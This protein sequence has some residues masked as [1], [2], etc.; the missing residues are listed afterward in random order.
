MFRI[1]T[2][3]IKLPSIISLLSLVSLNVILLSF[4]A[5]GSSSGGGG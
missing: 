2:K 3:Y 1:L 5:C 4:N